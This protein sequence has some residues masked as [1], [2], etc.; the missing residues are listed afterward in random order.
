MGAMAHVPR[1]ISSSSRLVGTVMACVTWD[2]P[3]VARGEDTEAARHG[4]RDPCSFADADPTEARL[5]VECNR[6]GA[7]VLAEARVAARGAHEGTR[8]VA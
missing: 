4:A 5:V 1:S 2:M 3:R 7:R 8:I 6:W